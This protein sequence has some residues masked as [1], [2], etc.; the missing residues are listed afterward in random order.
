MQLP[1]F[2]NPAKILAD[3]MLIPIKFKLITFLNLSII[4]LD[5]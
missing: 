3:N 4:K 1:T 2:F 5:C